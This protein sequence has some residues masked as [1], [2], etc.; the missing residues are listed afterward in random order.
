MF[1]FKTTTS[2]AALAGLALLA[3]CA[4]VADK[5]AS[6]KPAAPADVLFWSQAQKEA[7]FPKMEAQFPVH[8]VGHS[9]TPLALPQGKPL[10]LSIKG[11]AGSLTLDQFMTAQKAAGVLVIHNGKIRAEAYQLG[12]GPSGRW[13]SF[14]VAK[15]FTST[16][17]GAAIQDGYIKS[18]KD[19][20][21]MY[22]KDLAG[23]AYDKV[24]VE[25]LLTMTSGVAWNEDY[26]D[27][28]SDV[29]RL[30]STP[31]DPGLD[32]TVSYMR[33]LPRVAPP[34]QQ[35]LYKTGETNLIGVLVTAATHKTLADYLAEKIWRPFG[36]EQDAVWMIDQRGQEAGGCC[37]SVSLRDYGRM[38]LLMLG[39]G[40]VA[41]KPILPADWIA[42]ATSKRADIGAPGHGY[43]YQ[44]WTNDN[45]TYDAI[46]IFG[47]NIHIDPK[48]QLVVVISSAWPKATD[49]AASQM[50]GRLI[51]AVGQAVDADK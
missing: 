32:P 13:T 27:P 5:Q 28:K 33:K 39:G 37:I 49:P 10:T 2:F 26:T 23:S 36:M 43:G 22:I 45:G 17:V 47:Q 31:P 50:R 14:S 38:G 6:E 44:W 40:K 12:Y 21:T 51:E 16:L 46:G 20:V 11:D 48:R 41:G 25:Q 35:W 19:P 7:G 3:A 34:G 42:S 1:G 18:L 4:Q 29:A 30:F 8:T 9:Q 24:S 15:S